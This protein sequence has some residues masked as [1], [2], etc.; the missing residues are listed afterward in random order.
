MIQYRAG[1]TIGTAAN[2][3]LVGTDGRNAVDGGTGFDV[4]FGGAGADLFVFDRGDGVPANGIGGFGDVVLDFQSGVDKLD[5]NV[6]QREVT[7]ARV[8]DDVLVRY[9]GIA[10][11][12]ADAGTVLLVDVA[13]L[14][15][16]DFIW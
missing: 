11:Q 15:A 5:I 8:G 4:M 6:G 2:D 16:S 10:G 12:A 1:T 14:S 13:G 7:W 9:G 3:L